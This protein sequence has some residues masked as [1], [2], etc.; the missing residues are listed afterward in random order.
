M[1]FNLYSYSLP[2]PLKAD[3]LSHTTYTIRNKSLKC[4]GKSVLWDNVLI[5]KKHAENMKKIVGAI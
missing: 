1:N 2:K 5:K 4:A 3:Y